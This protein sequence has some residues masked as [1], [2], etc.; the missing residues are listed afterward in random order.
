MEA[1]EARHKET[2]EGLM[3]KI[4]EM[5]NAHTGQI[6]QLTTRLSEALE[7]CRTEREQV[8]MLENEAETRESELLEYKE[9]CEEVVAENAKLRENLSRCG[10]KKTNWGKVICLA[11]FGG[12]I[13]LFL[14]GVV[15]LAIGAV[16]G[17][18]AGYISD[19]KF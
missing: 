7:M 3:N 14:D 15:G 5:Q 13:G 2:I 18:R 17:G 10:V 11:I 19:S 12:V 9:K 4:E 16:Y 8:R 1:K 6:Q